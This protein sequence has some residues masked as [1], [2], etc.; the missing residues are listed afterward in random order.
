MPKTDIGLFRI[1]KINYAQQLI[2]CETTHKPVGGRSLEFAL[3]MFN[4]GIHGLIAF[5]GAVEGGNVMAQAD[6]NAALKR[7][8]CN[9]N[10]IT[11][12]GNGN[13]DIRVASIVEAL[14]KMRKMTQPRLS[15]AHFNASTKVD[16]QR[17]DIPE[18]NPYKQY[19]QAE[20]TI[21]YIYEDEAPETVILHFDN[22]ADVI[23]ITKLTQLPAQVNKFGRVVVDNEDSFDAYILPSIASRHKLT[24]AFLKAYWAPVL[25]MT[26]EVTMPEAPYSVPVAM[27]DQFRNGRGGGRKFRGRGRGNAPVGRDV[28]SMS[29]LDPE[30]Y[31][32]LRQTGALPPFPTPVFDPQQLQQQDYNNS[33]PAGYLEPHTYIARQP[34]YYPAPQPNSSYVNNAPPVTQRRRSR[35]KGYTQGNIPLSY[36]VP[37][38]EIK[39]KGAPVLVSPKQ[40]ASFSKELEAASGFQNDELLREAENLKKKLHKKAVNDKIF[41]QI[42]YLTGENAYHFSQC[43]RAYNAQSPQG[44]SAVAKRY[45]KMFQDSGKPVKSEEAEL[46]ALEKIQNATNDTEQKAAVPQDQIGR[47]NFDPNQVSATDTLEKLGDQEGNIVQ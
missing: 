15:T 30:S 14:Q 46:A 47:P 10:G 20:S 45:F 24:K 41:N 37:Q 7:G 44:L 29:P 17:F 25:K 6:P 40:R 4:N 23:R 18:F 5:V 28:P 26:G 12:V 36:P 16:L 21:Q 19:L 1:K 39:Q 2:D 34:Q 32:N 22:L 35:T 8:W 38:I 33:T 31:H 11:T 42:Y 9:K 43:L 13:F 27:T 3:S